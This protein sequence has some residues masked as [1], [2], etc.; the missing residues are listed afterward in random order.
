V[1]TDSFGQFAFRQVPSG[2]YDLV[3]DLGAQEVSINSLELSND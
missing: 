1:E 3:F 2:I